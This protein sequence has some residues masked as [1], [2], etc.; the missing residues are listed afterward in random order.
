MVIAGDVKLASI[1]TGPPGGNGVLYKSQVKAMYPFAPVVELR[2]A[3]V[4]EYCPPG[5]VFDQIQLFELPA[6]F[7]VVHPAGI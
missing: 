7:A 3:A 2:A 4:V 5:A 1:A 6:L